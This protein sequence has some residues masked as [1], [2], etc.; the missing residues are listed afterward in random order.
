M[1]ETKFDD[2]IPE[3]YELD[4]GR[5]VI[6]MNERIY[7]CFEKN[8][9]QT[10]NECASDAKNIMM[11]DTKARISLGYYDNEKDGKTYHNITKITKIEDE[12]RPVEE[13][14]EIPPKRTDQPGEVVY[15]QPKPP[16][17][18]K[19]IVNYNDGAFFGMCC[20]QAVTVM[21]KQD[22]TMGTETCWEEYEILVRKF[23]SHNKPLRDELL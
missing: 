12:A 23:F 18:E 21:M 9:D 4:N 13:V 14:V 15:P 3:K 22:K 16:A 11:H 5:V 17:S 7:A 19:K 10:T 6:R 8:K 20:N 1:V 2:G